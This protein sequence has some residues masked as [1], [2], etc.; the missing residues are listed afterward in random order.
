MNR[1]KKV[2]EQ[3]RS[4]SFKDSMT[5]ELEDPSKHVQCN[6]QRCL[7]CK[8]DGANLVHREDHWGVQEACWGVH[9]DE[10][11]GIEGCSSVGERDGAQS[12]VRS[13]LETRSE[14]AWDKQHVNPLVDL[15]VVIGTV[16]W[17]AFPNIK[18]V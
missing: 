16:E 12:E 7:L 10:G 9:E 13:E 2:V 5:N 6:G 14:D 17:K 18:I 15:V 3:C 1:L 8:I 4:A 11:H